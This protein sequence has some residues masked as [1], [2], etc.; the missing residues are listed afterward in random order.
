MRGPLNPEL[1]IGDVI[2]LLHMEGETSVPPGTIGVVTK[3][4]RDPFETVGE[5]LISVDWENGSRLSL[6][7]SQDAWKKIENKKLEEQRGDYAN[8]NFI[9]SNEDIF[10][11]FDWK[12]LRK[13]LYKIRESG[14][15][16][17]FGAAPLLYAGKEHIDRYY[18]EGREED[19]SFQHVLDDADEAKNKIIQGVL[20]Y[21]SNKDKDL[22]NIDMVNRFAQNF[23]NKIL[24]LYIAF[25]EN[26]N[27]D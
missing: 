3:I 4:S 25:S 20:S 7:T 2:L 23:A 9:T 18:G 14:I 10:E 21:M 22:D 1:K 17:M 11:H 27:L 13:F 12:F 5:N 8:W 15:I 19:E 26:R 16:N 24:G 6:V